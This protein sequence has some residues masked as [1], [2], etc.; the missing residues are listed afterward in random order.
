MVD[1]MSTNGGVRVSPTDRR[2]RP[3]DS[4]VLAAAEA[5]AR[6]AVRYAEKLLIDPAVAADLLE[7]AAATVSRA[8]KSEQVSK[9]PIR[10][11]QSYLFRAFLRRLNRTQRAELLAAAFLQKYVLPLDKSVNPHQLIEKKILIDEF[12]LQCDPIT[13]EMLCRRIEG[14][15]WKEIG[16]AYG[17]S[18]HAAESRVSQNFQKI[19][20]RLGFK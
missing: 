13:R 2:G 7:E 20:N 18:S 5:I 11:L 4:R 15:S 14:F 19:R 6:R 9:R 8:L 17:I 3:I 1:E 10:D 16:H 12:L